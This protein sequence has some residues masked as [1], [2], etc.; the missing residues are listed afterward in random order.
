MPVG[1]KLPSPYGLHDVHGDLWEWVAAGEQTAP[2]G[3][4]GTPRDL[5]NPAPP[6]HG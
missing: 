5:L 4:R 1:T 2:T 6:R 3:A